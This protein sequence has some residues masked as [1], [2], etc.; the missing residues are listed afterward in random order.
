MPTP[1]IIST[2]CLSSSVIGVDTTLTLSRE[3]GLASLLNEPPSIEGS[4]Y[5]DFS[6]LEVLLTTLLDSNKA[7]FVLSRTTCL[8]HLLSI[9][10]I[11]VVSMSL[12]LLTSN[13]MLPRYSLLGCCFWIILCP[14]QCKTSLCFIVLS[15]TSLYLF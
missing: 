8:P 6:Q 7:P 3:L 12:V 14:T 15:L 10:F 11:N 13:R 2:G 9:I 1:S 4:S 5:F